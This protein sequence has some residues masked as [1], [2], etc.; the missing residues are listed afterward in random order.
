M[1]SPFPPA[2]LAC[3]ARQL[4]GEESEP[5]WP[6]PYPAWPE[7]ANPTT[8]YNLATL[9]SLPTIGVA[10]YSPDDDYWDWSALTSETDAIKS[11]YVMGLEDRCQHIVDSRGQILLHILPGEILPYTLVSMDT[12]LCVGLSVGSVDVLRRMSSDAPEWHTFA[13]FHDLG[14]WQAWSWVRSTTT[15]FNSLT[16]EVFD[17]LRSADVMQR[18][19]FW[20]E[21]RVRNGALGEY[22]KSTLILEEMRATLLA[23]SIYPTESYAGIEAD[24]RKVLMK[25]RILRL[26]DGFI[27]TNARWT[28]AAVLTVLAE[29]S[30]PEDPIRGLTVLQHRL[31]ELQ[32]DTWSDAQWVI[33]LR[34][35]MKPYNLISKMFRNTWHRDTW[36]V[37]LYGANGKLRS[38]IEPSGCTDVDITVDPGI[39]GVVGDFYGFTAAYPPVDP[40][41][42]EAIF[43]ESLRQQLAQ[44]FGLGLVCPIDHEPGTCCGFGHYLRAVWEHV[45]PEY[46]YPKSVPDPQTGKKLFLRKP[47]EACLQCGLG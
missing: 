36:Q 7:L 35:R 10:L 42:A 1:L 29:L 17:L 34:E 16:S 5:V 20:A 31:T 45:P 18:A 24:L 22:L 37:N 8:F 46:R 39:P 25:Q 32:S 13:N 26:F 2:V 21:F 11:S 40:D 23:L 14:H 30:D 12:F 28:S 33:W 41:V 4:H 3:P 6:P 47:P 38:V 15:K 19:A 44:P 43:L 9:S 27:A